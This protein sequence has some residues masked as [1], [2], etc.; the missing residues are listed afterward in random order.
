MKENLPSI[1]VLVGPQGS[2]KTFHC[3][4]LRERLFYKIIGMGDILR[5]MLVSESEN[6]TFPEEAKQ[7]MERR[8]LVPDEY[9]LPIFKE[10]AYTKTKLRERK[11]YEGFPRNEV[12]AAEFL[13]YVERTEQKWNTVLIRLDISDVEAWRRINNAND[14]G[15][16]TDD[17]FELLQTGLRLFRE[18]TLPIIDLFRDRGI[19]IYDVPEGDQDAVARFIQRALGI[20]PFCIKSSTDSI[21]VSA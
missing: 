15:V 10:Y 4:W 1:I 11:V 17:T 18:R 14:R 2:G 3:R 20:K 13:D 7:C 9:I 8:E 16:R 12:Q 21:P 6:F 5:S 19:V